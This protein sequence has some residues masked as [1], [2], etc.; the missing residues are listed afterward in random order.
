M[1]RY[2]LDEHS[3][4][5]LLEER[6]AQELT[7]L[8][9]R[10]R[11]HLREWLPWLDNNRT[12]EDRKN[13]I[14]A[15]LKQLANNDGFQAG[16]WHEGRLAGVVGYHGINWRDRSTSLG[17][18]LG[19]EFEGR[20]LM[21]DSCRALTTHAFESYGLNRMTIVCATENKKSRAIPE[22]LGF[23]LEGVQ[24]QAEWLYNHFV[25][26]ALYGMLADDWEDA[27]SPGSG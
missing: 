12:V 13:F 24:R 10:N 21:T 14:R 23:E 26:H 25:D 20:G 4:L 19:K 27:Q 5:R 1:F 8:T 16:I 17:Y 15:T 7:E 22:R 3:E 6:H 11:E 2:E 18:W 9:D